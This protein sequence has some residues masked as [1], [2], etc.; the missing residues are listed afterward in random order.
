LLFIFRSDDKE[1]LKRVTAVSIPT[2]NALEELEGYLMLPFIAPVVWAEEGLPMVYTGE[3]AADFWEMGGP[4]LKVSQLL[5]ARINDCRVPIGPLNPLFTTNTNSNH[6][7]RSPIRFMRTFS[8]DVLQKPDKR[9]DF[10]KTVARGP[11][12]FRAEDTKRLNDG[13]V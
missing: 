12:F 6:G 13:R 4:C 5:L 1:R 7:Q 8:V 3:D 2:A 9:G 10:W 11:A